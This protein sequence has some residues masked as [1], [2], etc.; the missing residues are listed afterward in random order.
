MPTT[1]P[2][3]CVPQTALDSTEARCATWCKDDKKHRP[4]PHP[5][6]V[7]FRC[8]PTGETVGC[9]VPFSH[10]GLERRIHGEACSF[11]VPGGGGRTAHTL[12]EAAQFLSR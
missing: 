8:A 9:E 12:H 1:A 2:S 5:R 6:A 4:R 3:P 10:D 11:V 7:Q